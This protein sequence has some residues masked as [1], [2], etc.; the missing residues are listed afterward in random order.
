[1]LPEIGVFDHFLFGYADL[2]HPPS[3]VVEAAPA[4]LSAIQ[5]SI[6]P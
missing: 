6:L 1:M 5:L 2:Y 3:K 4:G